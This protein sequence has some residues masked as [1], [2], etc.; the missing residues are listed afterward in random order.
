[1]R[2][3]LLVKRNMYETIVTSDIKV[4]GEIPFSKVN[5]FSFTARPDEHPR[6]FLEGYVEEEDA[7]RLEQIQMNRKYCEIRQG[8]AGT[9]IFAGTYKSVSIEHVNELIRVRAEVVSATQML[10]YEKKS[11]SFQD[12]AATY[13]Q[14]VKEVLSGSPGAVALLSKEADTPIG[15]PLLQY[16]ETDWMFLKRLAGML[17]ISLVSDY[18]T[19][20]PRFS[21]G[22]SDSNVTAVRTP[23]YD[24]RISGKYYADGGKQGGCY[25]GDYQSFCFQERKNIPL[26]NKVSF[27]GGT[28]MV[29]EQKGELRNG[30][31][32]YTYQIGRQGFFAQ[33][34]VHGCSMGRVAVKGKI[35]STEGETVQ[36]A[37]DMDGNKAETARYS[38]PWIPVQGN[39]FYC[40]PEADTCAAVCF[41]E[42]GA[43]AFASPR[44]NGETCGEFSVP[45]R[46]SF[47]SKEGKRLRLYP[48]TIAFE[49]SGSL[50][51]RLE[52]MLLLESHRRL[53]I[54]AAGRI[55]FAGGSIRL[56]SPIQIESECLNE[57][58]SRRNPP[59]GAST[60]LVMQYQFDMLGEQGVLCGWEH[61]EYRA[62]EDAPEEFD[63]TGWLTNLVV[64]AVVGLIF[65][66]LAVLTMGA[67]VILAG[68]LVG[69]ATGAFVATGSMAINDMKDGEVTAFG[70]A[71]KE[72]AK[73]TLIGAIAGA[74][75]GGVIALAGV[76]GGA[77]SVGSGIAI[78]LSGAV[79]G[80]VD[81]GLRGEKI[82]PFNIGTDFVVS[83]LT[84]GIMDNI[85][86]G[87]ERLFRKAAMEAAEETV[88]RSAREI[89]GETAEKATREAAEETAEKIGKNLDEVGDIVNG[90]KGGSYV[91][92]NAEDLKMSQTVQNHMN[93]VIKKG[94]NAGQLSRPYIDSDGTTLLLKEIMESTAPVPDVVLQSGVRWDVS[95]T[96][97]GSTG[98]WELVVDTS[99]NTVVHFNF[100]SQ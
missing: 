42:H 6:L 86:R 60:S 85:M 19:F 61:V 46:R 79:E 4:Y 89:A 24:T 72:V 70:D 56:D 68:L 16:G 65:V 78:G 90:G 66:G 9:V 55:E 11:R 69:A 13:G 84:A 94:P 99:T 67:S 50:H 87:G 81:R 77:I 59:T 12:A 93:D 92:P 71:M 15:K 83:A 21:F 25:K 14:V 5:T 23:Q 91:L 17:G 30:E 64:G 95:G 28:F 82:T 57:K 39:A 31:L 35:I 98:T 51:L 43:Y 37:L 48:N 73:S 20:A 1:M 88:E 96:F 2:A 41:T 3:G 74:A 10:D 27:R 26:G 100:V 53:E 18:R 52:K 8:E 97:R 63:L 7:V 47:T 36:V 44:I 62:F 22:V 80:A 33:P 75:G 54:T 29:H 45:S 34:V 40:M 58:M 76:S 38:F 49:A 32:T